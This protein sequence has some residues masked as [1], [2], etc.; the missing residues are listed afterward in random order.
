MSEDINEVV[1]APIVPAPEAVE[2]PVLEIV[3][4]ESP[5]DVEI[6]EGVELNIPSEYGFQAEPVEHVD[7]DKVEVVTHYTDELTEDQK[8]GA[9]LIA[10]QMVLN[11]RRMEYPSVAEQL[12]ALYD[13]RQGNDKPIKEIDARIK[14]VKEKYPKEEEND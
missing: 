1:D 11:N 12:A 8:L 9:R 4:S 13:A 5:E 6:P 14:A 3:Y 10:P 7:A 2:A